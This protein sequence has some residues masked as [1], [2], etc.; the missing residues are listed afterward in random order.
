MHG[1]ADLFGDDEGAADGG[2][3]EDDDKLLATVAGRQVGAAFEAGGDGAGDAAQAF[4]TGLV[5]VG[6][7]E[8]FEVIDVAHHQGDAAGVA[9]GAPPFAGDVF[10]EVA[11]VGDAGQGVAGRQALQFLLAV[12]SSLARLTS[13]PRIW[14]RRSMARTLRAKDDLADRLVQVVVTTGHDAALDILVLAERGEE[15]DRRPAPFALHAADAS[16]DFEAV[17]VG[18]DD[19]EQDQIRAAWQRQQPLFTVSAG[20]TRRRNAGHTG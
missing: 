16:G 18:K 1:M 5:A 3:A 14:I 10:V 17:D 6:V 11:A 8:Q 9:A 13:E 7:V 15:D 19:V 20:M 4:V 12:S 2:L